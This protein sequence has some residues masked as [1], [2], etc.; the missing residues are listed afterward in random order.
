MNWPDYNSANGETRPTWCDV[1]GDGKQELVIGLGSGGEGWLNILDDADTEYASLSWVQVPWAGYNST[2]GETFPACGDLD[3]D[4][5]DELAIGLGSGGG[6]YVAILDDAEAGYT[7][8]SWVRVDW[9]SYTNT[10]GSVHPAVGN[11]DNDSADELILGLGEGGQGW[12]QVVD[13]ASQGFSTIKW[14]QGSWSIYNTTRGETFPL[15]CDVDGDGQNELLLG[16]GAGANGYLEVLDNPS[17]AHSTLGWPHVSWAAHNDA[18]GATYPACGD[19]DGD[20]RDELLVGLGEGGSGYYVALDDSNNG[21]VSLGWQRG[22]WASYNN[23][24]GAIHP[25]LATA[26]TSSTGSGLRFDL[27]GAVSLQ[28]LN[29]IVE[30]TDESRRRRRSGQRAPL[31]YRVVPDQRGAVKQGRET[32]AV[33]VSGGNL[34]AMDENGQTHTVIFSSH[35]AKVMYVVA[36]ENREFVYLALDVEASSALVAAENCAIFRVSLSDNSFTCLQEGVYLQAMDEAFV[37]RF[38]G[39]VKPI[40]RSGEGQIYFAGTPFSVPLSGTDDGITR[41]A[42]HP[43]IYR[44]DPAS[45]T[46]EAIT[47]DALNIVFFL[48][49]EDGGLVYQG[50][51]TLDAQEKLWLYQDPTSID[52]N[53]TPPPFFFRDTDRS[54]FWG[55]YDRNAQPGLFFAKPLRDRAGAERAFL[56][57]LLPT[58]QAAMADQIIIGDDGRLYGAYLQE[59]DTVSRVLIHQVLPFA[60]ESTAR[61]D[62]PIGG[63]RPITPTQVAQGYLYF[64]DRYD[65]G[66]YL[67]TKD[68]IRKQNMTTG[69]RETLLDDGRYELFTWRMSGQNLYFSG[70]DKNTTTL[71]FGWI[72]TLAVRLERPVE[73]YLTL[74]QVASALNTASEVLDIE[75]LRPQEPSTDP[76]YAPIGILS[77]ENAHSLS[78]E[79]GKYMDKTSVEENV[80]FRSPSGDDIELMKIWFY[81]T[82]HMI[83]DLDESGLGDGQGSTPLAEG[84]SYTLA[85]DGARDSYD[86]ELRDA[87][88]AV[89]IH[90]TIEVNTPPIVRDVTKT[91]LEDTT[92]R[93]QL[94]G[95]DADGDRITYRIVHGGDHGTTVLADSATG[96]F[97]YT[98]HLDV[99]GNDTVTYQASDGSVWSETATIAI[100]IIASPDVPVTSD[101]TATTDEDVLLSGELSGSD[102]DGD[103]LTFEIVSQGTLGTATLLDTATGAFSYAPL[104]DANG[105]DAWTFRVSDGTAYSDT[106]T[107]RITVTPKPDAP[108]AQDL[109]V[110]T[111]EGARVTSR[112]KATDVDGD[113]MFYRIVRNGSLGTA[114]LLDLQGALEYIPHA[115]VSG[116][117]HFTF[118]ASDGLLHSEEATVTVTIAPNTPPTLSSLSDQSISENGATS[119]IRFTVGDRE[120]DSAILNVTATS[121][122]AAL[123]ADDDI[124]LGGSGANRTVT[125]TPTANQYGST[126]V[127]LTVQDEQG[128]TTSDR[129][130]VTVSRL[131]SPTVNAHDG[132]LGLEETVAA[133]DFFSVT[134]GE[135]VA[136]YELKDS[137]GGGRFV[138]NGAQ[139]AEERWASVSTA[140]MDAGDVGYVGGGEAGSETVW[141]RAIDLH[142][143]L[144]ASAEWT[145]TVAEAVTAAV[146]AAVVPV[147]RSGQTTSYAAGDDGA[148]QKGVVWPIPRFTDH[149]DGTVTDRLTGLMWMKNANCWGQRTWSDT[150]A[151]VAALNGGTATCNGYSGTYTDWRVPDRKALFSLIDR[152]RISPALPSRHPF[153]SVQSAYYWS[154]TT[155]ASLTDNAWLV[156][157][158][159]GG[160]RSTSKPHSLYG[161]P[162]RGGR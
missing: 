33:L 92:G 158:Y 42:W 130:S 142:G 72:D 36:D 18:N 157:L 1:D 96:V 97:A 121:S 41:A 59:D 65:P 116:T 19:L 123:V 113:A 152:E 37:Q 89:G 55:S 144:S 140:A 63:M 81:R 156:D 98:P 13:D 11:L 15:L 53:Q 145:M 95:S 47:H 23:Q 34:L 143:D 24:T 57:T 28:A 93:W 148:L 85:I 66:D 149:G 139:L 2:N 105:D 6:G 131:P 79:F 120:S 104:T 8:L 161:W 99:H 29:D 122:H 7:L 60:H 118:T 84:L 126:T 50:S 31:I 151:R 76:G 64:M 146:T 106:A 132:S 49:L 43:L 87:A 147:P 159:Y 16:M 51:N 136:R 73:A 27:T 71:I 134:H 48:V 77:S 32:T 58:G 108:V 101:G 111:G 88:N 39:R 68:V 150:H 75:I 102:A 138:L 69:E 62:V 78:L 160:V 82:F 12:L 119:A 141:V 67:G 80:M 86:W 103:T 114:R 125:I 17:G 153:S 35:P 154:S 70:Q 9:S 124:Q 94:F 135:R 25:T 56:P 14:L 110:S 44:H 127:T 38:G 40:Q 91:V 83:P 22:H 52:L 155:R 137:V 21:F 100:T 26:T 133:K 112:L 54:L 30:E 162:V 115:D 20:G 90:A 46:T 107:M 117:D 74:Q 3:G 4:G 109:L 45:G 129:F 61:F 128:A 10:N 5:K